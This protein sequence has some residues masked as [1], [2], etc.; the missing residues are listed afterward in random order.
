MQTTLTKQLALYVV[1]YSPIQMAADLP[2][3]YNKHPDA[4]KFIQDV[5]TDWHKSIAIDGEVS[6]FVVVARQERVDTKQADADWFLGAITDDNA[7]TIEVKLDFLHQGKQYQAQIYRD[8]DGDNANWK[9][10]PYDYVIETKT[11]TSIDKLMLK[12]ASSGG[13]AIRFTQ[14]PQ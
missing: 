6:E 11:V 2:R 7:R 1:L 8:G 3:N 5:V 14:L 9:N 10:N 4:F 13:T 12:L